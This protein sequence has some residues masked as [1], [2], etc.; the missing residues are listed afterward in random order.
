MESF[1]SNGQIEFDVK[2]IIP[3]QAGNMPRLGMQF[4]IQ[5]NLDNI[6]IAIN[7]IKKLQGEA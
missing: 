1:L 3:D 2:M 5:K 4:E 6:E 7:A